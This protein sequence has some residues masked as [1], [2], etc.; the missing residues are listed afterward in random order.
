MHRTFKVRLLTHLNWKSSIWFTSFCICGTIGDYFHGPKFREG[1]RLTHGSGPTTLLHT[2][3]VHQYSACP[4]GRTPTAFR[5]LLNLM[6]AAICGSARSR[7][8]VTADKRNDGTLRLP[9]N[10]T[11]RVEAGLHDLGAVYPAV[12]FD[13]VKGHAADNPV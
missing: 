12:D 5:G 10:S 13:L 1:H 3:W 9:D 8:A 2:L 6:C 11:I 7:N 4:L